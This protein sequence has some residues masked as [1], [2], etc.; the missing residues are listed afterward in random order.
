MHVRR[1]ALGWGVFLI[2]AGAIPLAVRA[3]IMSEAQVNDLWQL[4]PMILI[5]LGVGLLLGRS[6]FAFIGG[7]IVAATFGIIIGGLLSVTLGGAGL[8]GGIC[9]SPDNAAA[10]PDRSSMF[11]AAAAD[12]DIETD[13][14]DLTIATKSGLDWSVS[15]LDQQAPDL[16]YGAGVLRVHSSNGPSLAFFAARS[17]WNVTIPTGLPVD[18]RT[19]LSA[20][21]VNVDLTGAQV[22]LADFGLNAASS[23]LDL[24]SVAAIR[25]L[26]VE[27][28]AGTAGIT[29]PN[30]SLTGTIQANA[31]SVRLCVPAGAGLRLETSGSIVASNDY[32]ANGLVEDEDVW[33][34]PGFDSATVRIDLKTDGNAASFTLDPKEGC[35]G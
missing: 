1:G 7:L 19:V 6:R 26:D 22:G 28:N 24:G 2:L 3:G 18:L 17:T 25:E 33:S 30:L 31:G 32:A 23:T 16:T 4:W 15:G 10:F 13:C 11:S 27:V 5:G 14:S 8:T 9:G 34:T 35:H 29:L 12:V 21:T 20:G